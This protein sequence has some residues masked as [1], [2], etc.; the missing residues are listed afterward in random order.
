MGGKMSRDKGKRGEREICKLLQ[1]VVNEIYAEFDL[2]PPVL[3]RNTLQSDGGGCDLAG[4][5]WL[6]IEV[7]YQETIAL[8][9]WWKQT[10]AQ[11]SP[12]QT[13]ILFYRRNSTK[14]KVMMFG[15]LGRPSQAVTAPVVVDPEFFLQWFRARL[16]E[17]LSHG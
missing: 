17:E 11:A 14:W 16:V 12:E 7:K 1:P 9:Q 8:S 2:E 4:L 5:L 10:L 13:P 15:M 6:A 3:K